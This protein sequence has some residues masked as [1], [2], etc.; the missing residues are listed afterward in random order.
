[1]PPLL[2]SF[3]LPYCIVSFVDVFPEHFNLFKLFYKNNKK[4]SRNKT[5]QNEK[6]NISN[7]INFIAIL[8]RNTLNL[9]QKAL[10]SNIQFCW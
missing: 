9:Q 1:M 4:Q 5:K 3:P 7:S 10:I 6:T 2:F 8:L